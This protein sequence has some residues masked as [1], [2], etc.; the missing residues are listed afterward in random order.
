MAAAALVLGGLDVLLTDASHVILKPLQ[1]YFQAQP[2]TADLFVGRTRCNTR[3]PVG[4]GL[5]WNLLF[6]R[7]STRVERRE[8]TAAFVHTSLVQGMI[9]FYLRWCARALS[10]PPI[11]PSIAFLAQRV[12]Y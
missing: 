7:G 5:T 4:C 6:L 12:R 9:D 2:H 10:Y 8:R 11:T 3:E 1:P